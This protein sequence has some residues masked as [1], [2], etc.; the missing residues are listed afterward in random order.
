MANRTKIERESETGR[1]TP[2]ADLKA[3]IALL[4]QHGATYYKDGMLELHLTKRDAVKTKD[5]QTGDRV[6]VDLG[7]V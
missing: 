1:I 5:N 7:K 4:T 3:R 2:L 6:D